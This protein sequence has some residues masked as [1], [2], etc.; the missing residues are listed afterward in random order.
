MLQ[1]RVVCYSAKKKIE[2][3]FKIYF[4]NYVK[5]FQTFGCLNEASLEMLQEKVF[6]TLEFMLKL[7]KRFGFTQ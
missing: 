6:I 3:T 4:V 2:V 1:T 7:C 5:H